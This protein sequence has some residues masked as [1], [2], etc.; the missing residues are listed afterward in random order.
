MLL[1]VSDILKKLAS[2]SGGLFLED[3]HNRNTN[4]SGRV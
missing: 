2:E 1:I 4:I 3:P